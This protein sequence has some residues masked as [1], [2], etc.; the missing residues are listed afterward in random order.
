MKEGQVIYWGKRGWGT[1]LASHER[2]RSIAQSK[3]FVHVRDVSPQR[4]LRVGEL[5]TFEVGEPTQWHPQRAVQ[6]ELVNSD[7]AV[8]R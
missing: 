8:Q 1:I 3:Y 5:V 7:S 4:D 2:D 6:V